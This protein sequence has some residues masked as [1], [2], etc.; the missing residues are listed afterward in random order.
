LKRVVACFEALR[1]GL[2]KAPWTKKGE[3]EG[4]YRRAMQDG[5]RDELSPEEISEIEKS[6][7][8]EMAWYNYK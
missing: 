2:S 3:P 6:L 1:G 5:W 7:A 4:F 8:E